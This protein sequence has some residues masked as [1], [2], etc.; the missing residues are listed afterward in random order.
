MM[1][2]AVGGEVPPGK[3]LQDIGELLDEL[4]LIRLLPSGRSLWR[5]QTHQGPEIDGGATASRLGTAPKEFARQ[6]N[7]MSP[8]GIPMFYAAEDSSTALAEVAVHADS[9]EDHATI[10]EFVPSAPLLVLDFTA[11][12]DYVSVFDSDRGHLRR[13]INFL[14]EFVASLRRPIAAGDEAI[15]YVPT[16]IMTEYFLRIYETTASERPRIVGI[17]YPSA[18]V[19]GGVSLVLDVNHRHCIDEGSTLAGGDL[20]LVLRNSSVQTQLISSSSSR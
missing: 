6:P 8:A 7:R 10:G 20:H 13:E 1:R 19:E 4:D 9:S 11:L 12:A 5:A 17:R 14:N 18:V 16:Q 15:E 2:C 3:V